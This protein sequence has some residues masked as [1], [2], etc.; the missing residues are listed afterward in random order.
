MTNSILHIDRDNLLQ[1]ER[2]MTREWLETDGRGGYASA[3]VLMCPTRRYHGLLV[4]PPKSGAPRHVF[5]APFEETFH[6]G[7]KTFPISMARYAGSWAPLGHQGIDSFELVPFPS[8]VYRFGRATLE[9]QILMVRGSHTVLVRYRVSGQQN[10]VELRLRPF[11]PCRE[12]DKLT[13]ENL[14]LEKRA[15]RI[16]S[17]V[18]C[19]PYAGLPPVSITVGSQAHFEADPVWYRGFEYQADLARGYDGHEDQF[20]PGMF[21]VALDPGVEVIVAATIESPVQDPTSLWARE[22]SARKAAC[23]AP[24]TSVSSVLEVSAEDFVYRTDDGRLGVIAGFPWFGEWGRDTFISLPGL[25]LSRGRVRECGDALEA[26]TAFLRRGLMPNIFGK[27]QDD[28]HYGSVDASLW[29]VR[30]VRLYELAAGPEARVAQRFLAALTE[31]GTSYKNGTDLAISCD[32]DGL[33]HAGSS[34]LNA[35]WMDARTAHGPVT[36]RDGCAVE[37]NALWYFLLAYLERLNI[38]AG[39]ES[40]SREWGSLKRRA[41]KSFVERFWLAEDHYLADAWKDGVADRSVRPNMVIAAALEFS[42]LSRGMRTDI[43][44]RAQAELL[45]PFG[46]RTLEPRNPSYKGRYFGGPEERDRAY[47]QGTVWPWLI[48]FYCEA[49]LRAFGAQEKSLEVLRELLDGFDE[50]LT[51]FGLAHVSEVLDGDPPYRPGGTIAQ[52]W[53]TAEI[54]RAYRLL[55]APPR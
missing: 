1:L 19:Q 28:S 46:L 33:I 52:A 42:P 4:A 29:F 35:T 37:I 25:L 7:G 14:A 15:R 10:K 23:R 9:R 5:V 48:G 32:A 54:L 34:E 53:N 18:T 21:H 16:P 27:G 38:D 24:R 2:S 11:L 45:T 12:A 3:S 17:G 44:Q 30:A 39:N 36:P 26:S 50:Q 49:Y 40:E 13:F 47:H 41:A 20:S 31:I 51:K 43:V 55:E 6:G 22:S 8:Y